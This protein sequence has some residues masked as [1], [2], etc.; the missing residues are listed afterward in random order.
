MLRDSITKE[1]NRIQEK[2]QVWGLDLRLLGHGQGV[3][4]AS[5]GGILTSANNEPILVRTMTIGD[6]FNEFEEQAKHHIY[7]CTDIL[8]L[9]PTRAT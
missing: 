8:T 4:T 5:L 1:F 2:Y 9:L 7:R 3:V 6:A